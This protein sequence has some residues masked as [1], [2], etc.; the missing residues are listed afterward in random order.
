MGKLR[1][2]EVAV[3]ISRPPTGRERRTSGQVPGRSLWAT[4][5]LGRREPFQLQE[6]GE[7]QGI[8]QHPLGWPWHPP[9]LH[10]PQACP[11]FPCHSVGLGGGLR[12]CWDK[13]GS[14][15]PSWLNPHFL[16]PRSTLRTA[17]KQMASE[18]YSYLSCQRATSVFSL[19][20]LLAIL[21]LTHPSSL[22]LLIFLCISFPFFSSFIPYSS[23]FP[24]SLCFLPLSSLLMGS[25]RAV[26]LFFF[27]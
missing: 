23:S 26:S 1:H 13:G 21:W 27:F 2:T 5:H 9:S 10:L 16:S 15:E 4:R 19:F 3:Y 8:S 12:V 22:P 17:G 18:W 25:K 11:P 24:H 6:G 20:P 7:E 14:E